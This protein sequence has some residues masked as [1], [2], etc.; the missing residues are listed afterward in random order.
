MIMGNFLRNRKSIRDFKSKKVEFEKLEEIRQDLKVF[1][2]ELGDDDFALRLYENGDMLIQSLTGKAGYAGVMIDAPHY[3]ALDFLNDFDSSLIYGAYNMEKI[4]TTLNEKGLSTCWISLDNLDDNFKKEVFGESTNNIE[5]LLAFGYQKP[6]PPYSVE[7]FSVKLGIEDFV[8][9]DKIEK[10]IDTDKLDSMGLMDLFYYIRFAPST[11]NLQPWRFI[12][13]D[14]TIE[15]LLAY[16][17]W[18]KHLF[19]DAGVI[20]YYFEQMNKSLGISNKWQL[21]DGNIYEGEKYK[22]KSIAVYQL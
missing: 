3:I 2:N 5:Y 14:T 8:F 16:E 7:P 15:L 1:H 4:I 21:L 18:N 13:K 11:K 9:S 17:E 10:E 12:L 22:Y 20:M 19:V 6:Q